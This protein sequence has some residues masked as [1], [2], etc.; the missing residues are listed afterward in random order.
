MSMKKYS[1]ILDGGAGRIICAIPALEKFVTE[2]SKDNIEVKI[3]IAGWGDLL[4]SN[5]ILQKLTYP[6]QQ[7]G[8]WDYIKDSEIII[9]EPYHDSQYFKQEL[10]LAET[11]AKLLDVKIEDIKPNLYVSRKE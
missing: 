1:I 8:N 4:D 11:F 9:P 10:H 7:K 3:F 2:K 6:I 5:P